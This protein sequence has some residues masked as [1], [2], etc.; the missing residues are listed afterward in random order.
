MSTKSFNETK[1]MC[2]FLQTG[3]SKAVWGCGG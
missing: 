3:E 2:V 1:S